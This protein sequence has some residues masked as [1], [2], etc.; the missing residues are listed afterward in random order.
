M[1]TFTT[2]RSPR[3][4]IATAE[5]AEPASDNPGLEEA[6]GAGFGTAQQVPDSLVELDVYHDVQRNGESVLRVAR[7]L[8]RQPLLSQIAQH[9]LAGAAIG[10]ERVGQRER[11]CDEILVQQG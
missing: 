1:Q 2:D 5:L 7:D 8:W 10:L 3:Q 4:S 6:S 11:E 9:Q